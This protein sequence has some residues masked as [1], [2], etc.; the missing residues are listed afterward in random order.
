M[1]FVVFGAFAFLAAFAAG[2]MPTLQL[3][4][5]SLYA[6]VGREA[7]HATSGEQPSGLGPDDPPGGL[8]AATSIVSCRRPGFMTRGEAGAALA[9]NVVQPASTFRW[10]R[11][12]QGEMAS[13]GFDAAK[14]RRLIATNWIRTAALLAQAVLASVVLIGALDSAYALAAP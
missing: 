5:Y 9:L 1:T 6:L 2:T 13:S 4:H 11:P 14:V 12:L 10:Q 7:S 8:A 3:Q